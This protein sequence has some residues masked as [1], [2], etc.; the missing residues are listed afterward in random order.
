MAHLSLILIFFLSCSCAFG[1]YKNFNTEESIWRDGVIKLEDGQAIQGEI[2]F[3]FV[4]DVLKVRQSED[5]PGEIFNPN[6]VLY[7][8]LKEGDQ[9]AL[10]YSLPYDF[11]E[12]GRYK[13]AFFEVVYQNG[14]DVL[15]ARHILEYKED[16]FV[17][18]PV[19]GYTHNPKQ[20]DVYRTIYLAT[21][22]EIVPVLKG[23]V[24][25]FWS[26]IF[27]R[28]MALGSDKYNESAKYS[29]SKTDKE[30]VKYKNI[31]KEDLGMLFPDAYYDLKKFIKANKIDMDK[32]EGWKSIIDYKNQLNK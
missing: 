26:F 10:F 18:D 9:K 15:L 32:V 5:E 21:G 25:D 2:N 30:K 31:L 8:E 23:R 19:L 11:N 17:N 13:P 14:K 16:D 20:E 4:S 12:D 3:N 24:K 6:K 27:D 1:Q 22:G 29:K 7:F 28:G